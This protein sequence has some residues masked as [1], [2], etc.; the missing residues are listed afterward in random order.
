VSAASLAGSFTPIVG[1][2]AAYLV[3]GEAPTLAQY[4]GGSLIL[5]GILLSQVGI[6]LQIYR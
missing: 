1:I 5:V 2:I 6:C 3:L 4:I